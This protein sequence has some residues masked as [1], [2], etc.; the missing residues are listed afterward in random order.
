L[1][2]LVFVVPDV[3]DGV[4]RCVRIAD[5]VPSID[6]KVD[7]GRCVVEGPCGGWIGQFDASTAL[8]E[9]KAKLT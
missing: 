7:V 2:Q 5:E 1:K 9:G 3:V 6:P 4:A 8:V